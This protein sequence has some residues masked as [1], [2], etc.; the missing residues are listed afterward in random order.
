MFK[1]FF[2]FMLF[3][4][5]LVSQLPP[6][7]FYEQLKAESDVLLLDVR[8]ME[9]YKTGY[10]EGAQWAGKQSVLDSLLS[11]YPKDGIVFIYCDYGHRSISVIKLLNKNGY[12]RIIELEG[13]LDLWKN[14]GF[15]LINEQL[16]DDAAPV[17]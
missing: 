12:K 9:D 14:Q 4:K 16:Q 5:V 11:Q 10:I 3:G 15:P 17:Q 13:G 6:F 2:L 8:T 7:E 1:V